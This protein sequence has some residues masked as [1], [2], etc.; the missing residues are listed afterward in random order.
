M[1]R[2]SSSARRGGPGGSFASRGGG[3]AAHEDVHALVQHR[4]RQHLLTQIALNNLVRAPRGGRRGARAAPRIAR[5]P[6]RCRRFSFSGACEICAD[7][8]H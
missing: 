1:P 6:H 5:S 2:V 7:H 3:G 4:F 8:T